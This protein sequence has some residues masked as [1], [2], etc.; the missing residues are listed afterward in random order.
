MGIVIIIYYT[1][2]VLFSIFHY[3]RCFITPS[4]IFIFMQI[5]MFTGIVFSNDY[6]I[7]Y[8][9]KLM[10]IYLIAL[11]FFIFGV[12]IRSLS[13][14]KIVGTIFSQTNLMRK[15]KSF[16]SQVDPTNYQT[17]MIF[18]LIGLSIIVCVWFFYMAGINIFLESI[19]GFINGNSRIYI[20]ERRSFTEVPLIGYIHQFR[21]IILPILNV[22][23]L[24]GIKSKKINKIGLLILPFTLIFLLGT[25]QR[26]A[27][28][29]TLIFTFI[30]LMILKDSY[31]L[32]ISKVK[33]SMMI[34]L[35]VFFL[36]ILTLANGRVADVN[37]NVYTGAL[38]SLIDR[39]FLINSR[40]ALNGFMYIE[41][42]PTVWGY[43]W[44]MMLAGILPI[45]INYTSVASI[46]YHGLYGT[47]KGTEPPCIWSSA[48]Y[49]WSWLGVILMPFI[50]GVVYQSIYIRFKR[51]PK[52]NKIDILV[53]SAL[54]TYLGLW[55]SDSPMVLFNNGV[56]TI[57]IMSLLLK[58]GSLKTRKR[59]LN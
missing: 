38:F 9:N 4:L 31:K 56:V 10:I 37:D 24:F 8:L 43:D 13:R 49:N 44:L 55:I 59:Q 25:G 11:I 16:Y 21:T 26:N 35:S 47:Y 2:S 27:F 57:L 58:F 46:V 3:K 33:L 51:I 17:F 53:Y 30:Y 52:K 34:G 45:D 14:K 50:L 28:I 36:V 7:A 32:K 1:I 41:S 12:S 48:Y 5:L 15:N 22:F 42:Q 29:F 54:C 40:A 39:I 19:K 6:P 20:E 23:L 18:I